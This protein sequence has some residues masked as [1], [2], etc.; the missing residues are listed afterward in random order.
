MAIGPFGSNLKVS[1]YRDEGV[2][3]VF[4]R[5]IRSKAFNPWDLKYVSEAKAADL[6]SHRVEQGDVLVTKMGDPPG[7]TA[8]YPLAEQGIVTADCIKLALHPA[9]DAR[10][11]VYAL[12][13]PAVKGQILRITQGVAQPKMSLA[14]FRSGIQVPLAPRAEQERIVTIIEEQFSRVDA[15]VTALE[16]A[17]QNLR[18]MRAAVLHAAVTGRMTS[19]PGKDGVNDSLPSDWRIVTVGDV[20]EVSGGITK[21]P[22]RRP[23]RN[24]IPF[25]RVANVRRDYL[26]LDDVHEVEVFDGELERM[27][28]RTGDLLVVE[29]NGSP[30]QIGRSA[31]WHGAIDPCVH[32]NHLIRVRPNDRVLPEYLN[33]YWNAPSSMA[34][35]QAAASSTSGLHT[36]ST[37]KVRSIPV[38]LP[39]VETQERVVSEAK[40]QLSFVEA[41]E[42]EL[43]A[44]AKR[45]NALR[46]SILAAAFA[47]RLVPQDPADEPARVLL[48]S[49]AS[50]R[51]ASNDPTRNTKRTRRTKVRT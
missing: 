21:N 17:Q 11:V 27:R 48:E 15:G 3:L 43:H 36:L 49:I 18:R 41:L 24:P 13:T 19:S 23:N 40:R 38:A 42:G 44:T 29:G 32:Q 9:V 51:A 39:P 7:D 22:K 14:R 33:L 6:R 2:P 5:N 16:R 8:I 12:A 30:D 25:L 47:G 50:G 31:L 4:V 46:S 28:L 35:I 26:D 37:G 34:T 1:D 45:S 20:A 10:F